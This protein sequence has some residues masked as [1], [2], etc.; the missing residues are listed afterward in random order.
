MDLRIKYPQVHVSLVIAGFVDTDFHKIAHTPFPVRAGT[1]VG[2]AMVQS[3]EEVAGQ[4]AS[5]IEHPVAELYTNPNL[6]DLVLQYYQD[7]GI[8][9]KAWAKNSH[10]IL[11]V[12]AVLAK[13]VFEQ[14]RITL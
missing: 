13:P 8:S 1:R 11:F 6:R 7:V 12:Q 2:Q 10:P 5:L 3:A 9:K 14:W 4:I